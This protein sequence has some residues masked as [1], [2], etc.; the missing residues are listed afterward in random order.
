M[1]S[2]FTNLDFEQFIY[3]Q[4]QLLAS[5]DFRDQQ[6]MEAAR[7]WMHNT[8]L[9]N[10]WGVAIGYNFKLSAN[11]FDDITF[12]DIA[13]I[14]SVPFYSGD[15]NGSN[16]EF[17][18]IPTG[19]ILLYKTNE[20]RYGK[21]KIISY[22]DDLTLQWKTFNFDGSA[23]SEGTNLT[24]RGGSSYDLDIGLETDNL[25][26]FWWQKRDSIQRYLVP[27]NG[28]KLIS[29]RVGDQLLWH[30]NE[31]IIIQPGIAYDCFGRE[32]ILAQP[33]LLTRK[34]FEDE[35]GNI[36][37]DFIFEAF[38]LVLCHQEVAE[39]PFKGC[40]ITPDR[41]E[42]RPPLL[43]WK[44]KH[45]VRLGLEVPILSVEF[46]NQAIVH[47]YNTNPVRPQARPK[48]AY[49]Q[50][51]PGQTAWQTWSFTKFNE[52]IELGIKVKIETSDAGFQS[53]PYYFAWLNGFIIVDDT[54]IKVPMPAFVS[55][56]DEKRDSFTFCALLFTKIKSIQPSDTKTAMASEQKTDFSSFANQHKLTVYWLGI[57]Y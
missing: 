25:P 46:T 10:A 30:Q 51:T 50:T 18:E 2:P 26:D 17:N 9:H 21:L 4:G 39:S 28:A 13:S 8:A 5:R 29:Y 37:R 54:S 47:Q 45:E 52:P 14:M 23:F 40:S 49:G 36:R 32:L 33:Q 38:F 41:T 31:K 34:I 20:D 1:Q 56:T 53:K 7:R 11:D 6:R 57:E 24:I 43:A 19:S 22:G 48:I 44:R 3:R 27:Q 42:L 16:N 15:I 35:T 55:L 12:E